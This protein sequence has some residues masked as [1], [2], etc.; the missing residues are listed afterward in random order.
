MEKRYTYSIKHFS[1]ANGITV[2]TD[3]H[4]SRWILPETQSL[5]FDMDGQEI[6]FG[7]DYVK[8]SVITDISNQGYR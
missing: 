8:N 2:K 7:V 4:I 3:T 5:S 6:V 1:A